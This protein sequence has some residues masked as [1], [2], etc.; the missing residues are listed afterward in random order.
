MRRFLLASALAVVTALPANAATGLALLP[1]TTGQR[2]TYRLVHSVQLTNGTQASSAV[3]FFVVRRA[4][5]TLVIERAGAGGAP[6]LSI[7]TTT[8]AGTLV[9]ADPKTTAADADLNDLL[10]ALNLATAAT[11]DGDPSASGTWL[12]VVPA[13]PAPAPHAT[14]PL[15]LVPSNV[16]GANFDFSGTVRSTLATA[17]AR[18]KVAPDACG[19]EPIAQTLRVDGH[20][21]AGHVTRVAITQLRTVI[22][23]GS[24]YANT[25]S[26]TLTVGP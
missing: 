18:A 14:A 22:V 23:A 4:G 1:Q 13:D 6:N 12:G 15:V 21:V 10:Y 2:S 3:T 7:L 26:W 11:R 17:P 24:P 16:A 20:V 5:T 19:P 8:P 25:S 9:S